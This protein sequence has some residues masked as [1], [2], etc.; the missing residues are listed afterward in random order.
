MVRPTLARRRRDYASAGERPRNPRAPLPTSNINT[1]VAVV[2][3]RIRHMIDNSGVDLVLTSPERVS[4]LT[5]LLAGTDVR[6]AVIE[7]S[8]PATHSRIDLAALVDGACRPVILDPHGQREESTR[9]GSP[10]MPR[11]RGSAVT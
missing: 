5:D 10:V 6:I 2:R 7:Q 9:P 11:R 3:A 1:I 4:E 8:S